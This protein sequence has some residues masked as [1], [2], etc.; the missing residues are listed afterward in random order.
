MDATRRLHPHQGGRTPRC[1]E[2]HPQPRAALVHH[3]HVRVR[4]L[5]DC[6]VHGTAVLQDHVLRLL[7]IGI[8]R[9]DSTETRNSWL[10]ASMHV[11]Q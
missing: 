4:R 7:W 6:A 3:L 8:S 9:V 2:Q 1:S 5:G 11:I 10:E